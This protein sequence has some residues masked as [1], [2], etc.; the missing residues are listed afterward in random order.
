MYQCTQLLMWLQEEIKFSAPVLWDIDQSEFEETNFGEVMIYNNSL[1]ILPVL[2]RSHWGAVEIEKR[3]DQT[4]ITLVQ[5]QHDLQTRIVFIV[6]RLLDIAPHRLQVHIAPEHFQEHL[7]GWNLLMR[8]FSRGGH[9][10]QLNYDDPH[11]TVNGHQRQDINDALRSSVEDLHRAGISPPVGAM[12]HRLR[13]NSLLKFA[14]DQNLGQPVVP[15][16]LQVRIPVRANV[17]TALTPIVPPDDPDTR[18]CQ[19]IQ[20]RLEH[21]LTYSG[22]LATDEMDYTLEGPRALSTDTL[23]CAPAVWSIQ[24]ETL[25]FLNGLVPEYPAFG[26]IIWFIVVNNHWIM[27]EAF[28]LTS[29]SHL[30]HVGATVPV[31]LRTTLRPLFDHWVHI[32]RIDRTT[33]QFVFIDQNSPQHLCGYQ[34]LQQIFRRLDAG[35]IPITERQVRPQ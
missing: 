27:I 18:R 24:H 16:S 3:G 33:L 10:A 7:C 22:W 5:I 21:F 15:T 11:H 2:V 23:F 6:A 28:I 30:S 1:T 34:L 20:T 14:R 17:G 12:A 13:Y 25:T 4:T 35:Q 19:R 8:W 26:H 9:H 32:A 31:D 29:V